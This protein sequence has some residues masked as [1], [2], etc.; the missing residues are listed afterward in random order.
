VQVS[1]LFQRNYTPDD[2]INEALPYGI[3]ESINDELRVY[4]YKVICEMCVFA[5]LPGTMRYVKSLSSVPTQQKQNVRTVNVSARPIQN[6]KKDSVFL[7]K[8][9]CMIAVMFI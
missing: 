7:D 9:V 1:R 6:T 8:W 2:I 5:Q 4:S 3:I